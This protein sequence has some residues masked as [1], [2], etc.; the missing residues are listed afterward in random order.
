LLVSHEAAA[1][2]PAEWGGFG[3]VT[4]GGLVGD[5]RHV[6]GDLDDEDAFGPGFEVSPL[7]LQLGGGGRGL[8]GQWVVLGGRG[9]GWF[10]GGDRIDDAEI[11]LSGGGGGFDI[12]IA[13]FNRDHTLLYPYVGFGGYGLSFEIASTGDRPLRFGAATIAPGE[14][15]AFSANFFTADFGLGI[16]RMMFFGEREDRSDGGLLAGFEGGFLVPVYRGAI[17]DDL[18]QKIGGV[19]DLGITG[20]Y[21]RL[22]LGGGG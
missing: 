16:Q 18:A 12:G 2:P 17:V 21:L 13:A 10:V 14:T 9:M 4:V 22:T 11:A 19:N 1:K 15:R 5:W 8:L 20:V 3:Y 7:A 6:E